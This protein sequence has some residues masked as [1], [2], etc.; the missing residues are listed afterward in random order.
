[1]VKDCYLL[2]TW[3]VLVSCQCPIWKGKAGHFFNG[4]NNDVTI[5]M[6]KL[7]C[8]AL[9]LTGTEDYEKCPYS[10][11]F[12]HNWGKSVLTLEGPLM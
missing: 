11:S 1:M 5:T 8:N 9:E 12:I 7:Y 6:R 10:M 4:V 3:I 2:T